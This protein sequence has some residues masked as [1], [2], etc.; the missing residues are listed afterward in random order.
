MIFA[1]APCRRETRSGTIR[2][3]SKSDGVRAFQWPGLAGLGLEHGTVQ[4]SRISKSSASLYTMMMV[5]S[6]LM[7]SGSDE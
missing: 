5:N 3:H 6:F 4:C 1:G 2:C 7:K